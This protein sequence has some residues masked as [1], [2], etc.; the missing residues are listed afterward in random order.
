MKRGRKQQAGGTKHHDN[1]VRLKSSP[2]R[3]DMYVE[4]K[5]WDPSK[6]AQA[7][8]GGTWGEGMTMDVKKMPPWVGSTTSTSIRRLQLQVWVQ[9]D[10]VEGHL[11]CL[12]MYQGLCVCIIRLFKYLLSNHFF[13]YYC[14]NV[15]VYWIFFYEINLS[16][17]FIIPHLFY[18]NT[19]L[20]FVAS[21]KHSS[22]VSIDV[23]MH[24]LWM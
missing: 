3:S 8:K 19:Y 10:Q 16:S 20:M 21:L 11:D 5:S 24:T 18:N 17:K 2:T 6:N 13:K 4:D 22:L 1:K 15:I 9:E 7:S 14:I 23:W 12:P